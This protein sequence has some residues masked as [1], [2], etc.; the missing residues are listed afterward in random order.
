MAAIP[1]ALAACRS[2]GATGNP[3]AGADTPLSVPARVLALTPADL[4]GYSLHEELAPAPRATGHDDPYGR[5]GSYSATYSRSGGTEQV[6]SSVNTYVGVAQARAAFGD[7]RAAVPRQYRAMTLDVG[8]DASDVAAFAREGD[9]TVLLG[10]R[11]RNVLGSVR[12]PAAEVER[13]VKL[14][15]ARCTKG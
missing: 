6:T 8:L 10:Y 12:A 5:L 2:S 13:L 1:L 11:I 14:A 9:G 15:L 4:P 3:V 7:W